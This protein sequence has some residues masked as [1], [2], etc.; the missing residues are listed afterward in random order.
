M[1]TPASG[2]VA[3][4]TEKAA[5]LPPTNRIYCR[6]KVSSKKCREQVS[7]LEMKMFLAGG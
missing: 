3:F 1:L 5:A 2:S 6:P 7:W 4:Y